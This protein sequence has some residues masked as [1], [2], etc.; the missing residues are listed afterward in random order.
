MGSSS[1]RSTGGTD[2]VALGAAACILIGW[3]AMS[4]LVTEVAG[5]EL[6]FHFYNL[7][8][9]L[10]NPSRLLTGL[11]GGD[12]LRGFVFGLLCLAVGLTVFVPYRL[13]PRGAWLI[14]LAPLAL[15]LV[16][17]A[18]LYE[19][20]SSELF[21]DSGRYGAI[22]SQLVA[23]ANKVADRMSESLAQHI[24]LGFG[25]YL[26]FAASLV[27]AARGIARFRAPAAGSGAE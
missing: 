16:C 18:L 25:A 2:V 22:E 11:A 26:S 8:S 13:K 5:V 3:F 4:T 24:T 20:T 15:M 9:V 12:S 19:R 27:L 6:R 23:F 7:W 21:A 1:D 14:Y 10:E 17:G